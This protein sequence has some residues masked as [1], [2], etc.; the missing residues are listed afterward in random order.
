MA[1][2]TQFY[3]PGTAEPGRTHGRG[4]VISGGWCETLRVAV[5]NPIAAFATGVQMLDH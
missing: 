4:G 5:A 3:P 2:G 1:P